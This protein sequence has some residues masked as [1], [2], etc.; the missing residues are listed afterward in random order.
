MC[1]E[2]AKLH[3]TKKHKNQQMK[4]LDIEKLERKNIYEV[5]PDFFADLQ[6]NVLLQTNPKKEAKIVKMN[7]FYAVAAA[8]AMVFGITFVLV[9]NEEITNQQ[10]ISTTEKPVIKSTTPRI[11]IEQDNEIKSDKKEEDLTKKVAVNPKEKTDSQ[12]AFSK[13]KINKTNPIETVIA[14]NPEVQ[15]DQILANFTSAELADLGKNSE[16]DVY[17][18]LYN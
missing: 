9:P 15:M 8:L 3:L 14:P 2:I 10:K 7:W 5:P 13:N 17:L 4:N 18:D 11:I 12:V 1:H 16:Q 6:E